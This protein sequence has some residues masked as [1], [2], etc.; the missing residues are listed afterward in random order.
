MDHDRQI[1]LPAQAVLLREYGYEIPTAPCESD[2]VGRVEGFAIQIG[3]CREQLDKGMKLLLKLFVDQATFLSSQKLETGFSI[4]NMFAVKY[5]EALANLSQKM[6]D[7]IG[8]VQG[9]LSEAITP[10]KPAA[11]IPK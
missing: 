7:F 4:A 2:F 5:G 9:F 1:L 8:D 6:P 11:T 10:K 3:E